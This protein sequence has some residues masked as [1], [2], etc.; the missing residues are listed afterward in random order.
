MVVFF[1][2]LRYSRSVEGKMEKGIEIIRLFFE[3]VWFWFVLLIFSWVALCNDNFF[4][5]LGFE[6]TN[7]WMVGITAIFATSICAE[8]IVSFIQKIYYRQS[9]IND[10]DKL[11]DGAKV[12]LSHFVVENKKTFKIQPTQLEQ[13]R[14]IAH[15]N[16]PVHGNYATFPDYLWEELRKR[17]GQ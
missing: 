8:V 6:M 3:K 10:I 4:C 13:G 16:L 12:I 17:Y 5:W 9:I 2:V 14:I 7:R 11:T 15:L 1:A